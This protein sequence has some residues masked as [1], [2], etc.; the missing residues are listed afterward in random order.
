MANIKCQK[1]KYSLAF[2]KAELKTLKDSPKWLPYN[3]NKGVLTRRF[4]SPM[5][6]AQNFEIRH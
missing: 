1:Y 3:K 4:P 2:T 6:E 5:K